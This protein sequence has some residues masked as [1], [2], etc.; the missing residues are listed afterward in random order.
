MSDYHDWTTEAIHCVN[1]LFLF[2]LDPLG[3]AGVAFSYIWTDLA[4][5]HTI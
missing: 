2:M 1:G 5:I 3:G 4:Q